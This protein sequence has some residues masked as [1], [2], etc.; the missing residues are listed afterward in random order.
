MK[1]KALGYI[2]LSIGVLVM[3]VS[4]YLVYLVLS[5]RITPFSVFQS[6]P[7][8]V[9]SEEDTSAE[10][11]LSNPAAIAKMQQ[12]IITTILDK[13]I[14]KSMNLGATIFLI[15]FLMLFGFRLA[16]LGTQ[17]VRP[18]HVNLS[19]LNKTGEAIVPK[20]PSI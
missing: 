19:T 1:E 8:V 20:P 17:L 11:L 4:V 10:E 5:N 18:I 15:Y 3:A 2:F 12:Q 7:A 6:N 16:T 14:N 9:S 13:Q